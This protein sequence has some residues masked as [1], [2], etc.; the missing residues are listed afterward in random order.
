M[1]RGAGH[2]IFQTLMNELDT[3]H[4]HNLFKTGYPNYCYT[5]SLI[6]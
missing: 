4:E 1:C 2:T 6:I 3:K 5:E